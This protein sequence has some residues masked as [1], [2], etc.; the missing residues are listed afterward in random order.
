VLAK[1]ERET[2]DILFSASPSP[3]YIMVVVW[4]KSPGGYKKLNKRERRGRRLLYQS[5]DDFAGATKRGKWRYIGSFELEGGGAYG[6]R[7]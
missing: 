4:G 3:L 5:H 6:A 2:R 7:I 1:Q